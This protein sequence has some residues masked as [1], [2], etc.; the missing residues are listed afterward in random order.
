MPAPIAYADLSHPSVGR[1]IVEL[2]LIPE[3]MVTSMRDV[4]TPAEFA[5]AM[6][7]RVLR[8]LKAAAL[9]LEYVDLGARAVNAERYRQSASRALELL[10]RVGHL[11]FVRRQAQHWGSLRELQDNL[12]VDEMG[13]LEV[14]IL[15]PSIRWPWSAS[16]R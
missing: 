7:V 1:T 16:A 15:D 5:Q 8:E 10:R 3:V 4:L 11:D 6:A 14:P 2:D 9:E 12:M 13:R